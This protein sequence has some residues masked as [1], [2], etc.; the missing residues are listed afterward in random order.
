[1]WKPIGDE[2]IHKGG[3]SAGRKCGKATSSDSQGTTL[4]HRHNGQGHATRSLLVWD[5]FGSGVETAGET[6]FCLVSVLDGR[7]V[8]QTVLRIE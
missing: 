4:G 1:M 5:R 2:R 3:A 7:A 6:A 8:W